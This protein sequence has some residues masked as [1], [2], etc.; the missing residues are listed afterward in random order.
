MFAPPPAGQRARPVLVRPGDEPLDGAERAGDSPWG[1]AER[2][3][4]VIAFLAPSRTRSPPP[5]A[6]ARPCRPRYVSRESVK[7]DTVPR[8]NL[9]C[10][11]TNTESDTSPSL[12]LLSSLLPK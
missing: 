1:E 5:P 4:A 8:R 2:A 7:G 12:P 6:R 10:G 9:R 3:A 11:K